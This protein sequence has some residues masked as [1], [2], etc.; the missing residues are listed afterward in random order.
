VQT[1]MSLWL[2]LA[3]II[4][5]YGVVVEWFD[6]VEKTFNCLFVVDYVLQMFLS[7]DR[8]AYLFGFLAFVD[9]LTIMP[10]MVTWFI[11][12]S[13]S[14]TSV[15]LR[16]VRLSKLFRILRSFRLIRASSQDIYR[17]LFLL[18]LTMVCLIFTAAGFYQLIENNWR[19]ARGEPAIL[20]FD[21]AMYLAT[22]EILGRP[23]LQLTNASGHIFWIFMVVVSIVLIPKQLASIFQILQK[24]PFARQTK[25]VKHHAN[26]IV[27]IGHTE[28]S[29]LN[30]L[31][32]EAYHPD[33]GPLRPCDI[34]ILAP[35]E[36]CAQT[37][38]LLSHPSYH[39]FVQYIQGS[40]HYDIDLR[41]VRVEDAMALMVM[42]NKYP[43]DPAW[44]DTQVASMI[45]A[46]KA[47]KNAMLHKT[48]GFAGRR[49]LRVLAQVL[50]SD[51]RDRIVQMPGWDR[52]QDVC[53][54]I[55]ELTAAMI[56]MSSL[57][58]GV[59]TMVLNLVSHTTQNGS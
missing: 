46:C 39:G 21:Q 38:D 44:E 16:I 45:L 20:P 54:V 36:P 15:V 34:V 6:T 7:Q 42:A 59:A 10:L 50:S 49:K 58:R 26:H 23:R 29:V 25:Y 2:C 11:F 31:L 47:Y 27:I 33:R 41:R 51:T 24:D 18:G 3:Y 17:E 32:Y 48:S 37:K 56:A 1:G 43:T 40:P 9:V 55:G 57:H 8:L 12:R 13:E 53:L 22:I 14:D 52:I 30:T 4:E 35:S 5:S 19:L 28:F